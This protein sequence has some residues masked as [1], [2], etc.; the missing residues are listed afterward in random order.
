MIGCKGY[1]SLCKRCKRIRDGGDRKYKKPQTHF[2]IKYSLE[3]NNEFKTG[4]GVVI[5]SSVEDIMCDTNLSE[6]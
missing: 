6:R 1:F 5:T 3:L 4:L 2:G